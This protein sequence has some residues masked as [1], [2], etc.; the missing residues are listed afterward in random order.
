MQKMEGTGYHWLPELYEKLGFP[1]FDGVRAYYKMKNKAR[2]KLRVKRQTTG[3]QKKAYTA[4]HRHRV[5]EQQQR[6][7]FNL[8]LKLGHDYKPNVGFSDEPQIPRRCVCGATDH[9][10]T[11]HSRCPLNPRNAPRQASKS[12]SAEIDDKEH[13]FE[14]DDGQESDIDKPPIKKRCASCGATDHARKSHK[15]CPNNPHNAPSTSKKVSSYESA[16][17]DEEPSEFEGFESDDGGVFSLSEFI[18]DNDSSSDEETAVDCICDCGRA[19]KRDC[20]LNPRY[21]NAYSGKQKKQG[22]K[23]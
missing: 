22:T 18:P 21:R 23:K 14:P 4:K 11:T 17:P 1:D 2:E 9:V 5:T 12:Q 6:Q 3:H 10:K 15:N 8:Q 19:H 16:D 7:K 13:D 20:P